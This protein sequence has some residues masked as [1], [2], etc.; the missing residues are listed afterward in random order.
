MNWLVA[1][2]VAFKV[3]V[4]PLLTYTSQILLNCWQH[5]IKMMPHSFGSIFG[6]HINK[7]KVVLIFYFYSTHHTSSGFFLGIATLGVELKQNAFK[8]LISSGILKMFN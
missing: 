6:I 7:Y 2:E 1:C 3:S 8:E 5:R 4:F